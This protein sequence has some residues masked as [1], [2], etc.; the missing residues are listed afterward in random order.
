MVGPVAIGRHPLDIEIETDLLA[1]VA[2]YVLDRLR[3]RTDAGKPA[4]AQLKINLLLTRLPRL[5]SGADP[6]QAFAGTFHIDEP[7][8]GLH[9]AY[10]QSEAGALPD[11]LPAEVYCHTLTDRTILG[12][13]SL[14]RGLHTLTLFGLHTPASLYDEFVA[15]SPRIAKIP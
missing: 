14:A 15:F 6:R 11:P 12:P 1:G 10:T 4:G 7:Y 3:G 13:E 9:T 5:R 2:P 8:G